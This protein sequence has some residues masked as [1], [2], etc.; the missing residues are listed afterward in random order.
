MFLAFYYA[1]KSEKI[2]VSLQ[3]HFDLLQVLQHYSFHHEAITPTRFYQIARATLVKD[4]KYY[5]QFDQVFARLFGNQLVND[6]EFRTQLEEWLKKAHHYQ[7][8]EERLRNALRI[9][10]KELLEQLEKRLLEQKEQHHGGNHWIGTGGTSPFGHSG[11][12]PQGMRIG[13]EGRNKSALAV[14]GERRYRE[15]RTDEIL[16]V[17]QI[18]L[19]LKHL[20]LLKKTGP[21][22]FSLEKTI[23]ATCRQGGEI[24]IVHAK[25]RKNH[26][27]LI[28]LLDV[29]GSMTPHSK[30]VAK[31]FSALHQLHHF[32]TFKT[33][34]FHNIFYDH[35]YTGPELTLHHAIALDELPHKFD[36]DTRVVIVG[37]AAM[38]PYEYFQMNGV[39]RHAYDF[40]GRASSYPLEHSL[41][42]EQRLS[43]LVDNYPYLSWLNPEPKESWP[44]TTT[45]KAIQSRVKMEE[46]T[47]AGLKKAARFLS[48]NSPEQDQL[49][50]QRV[51]K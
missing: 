38:A 20:R 3:E 37:D 39:L 27:K 45:I 33:Y 14:L 48:G 9:P 36:R 16:H 23:E 17:R 22:E 43:F 31:L 21:D 2:P 44:Y 18:K 34:Y 25:A 41:T 47:I 28:L 1:L 12:N 11:Y 40:Y 15:Y 5:D 51:A 50:A 19:A 46:L 7:L 30:R 32:K 10:P 29:G 26:L 24:D 49:R 4:L 42:G 13:G 35:V 6:Q 8:D